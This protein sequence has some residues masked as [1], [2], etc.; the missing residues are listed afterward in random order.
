VVANLIP[1][2]KN[3]S[4][5]EVVAFLVFI[6]QMRYWELLPC[7]WQLHLKLEKLDQ[8]SLLCLFSLCCQQM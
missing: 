2:Q 1:M 5:L 3:S 8:A 4:E 7:Q 6:F